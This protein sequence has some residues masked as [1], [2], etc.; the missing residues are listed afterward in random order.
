MKLAL[1]DDFRLGI[2]SNDQIIDAEHLVKNKE[3]YNDSMMFVIENYDEIKGALQELEKTGKGKPL[4]EVRLRQPVTK[5]GKI[6]AAP[7]NYLKHQAEMNEQ[8]T[9]K[10]LGVFL[11]ATSSII[12]QGDY[13]ELPFEDRRT[14]HELELGFVIG[15]KGKDIKP[16]NALDY[17]FGYICL[18]DV[19]IRGKEDRS[20][21]KSFDT[22]TPIG[23]W[24]VT[25]DEIPDP[26]NLDIKLTVNGEIRQDT[27]TK[28]LIYNVPKIIEYAS[29]CYTLY[30]GDVF[31][32]GTPEGVA[33]IEAGDEVTLDVQGVGK[34]TNKVKM[35]EKK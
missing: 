9:I 29:E 23:P 11:K 28:N 10:D 25:K 26:G 31:A 19:V 13:I 4:S 17:I 16:E 33:P 18:N 35:K 2:V 20:Y 24:I 6:V 5:P 12:G 27:N 14:D 30:P 21:R 8:H 22:F 32:T 1:Y 15:K 34:L 3:K 7:V